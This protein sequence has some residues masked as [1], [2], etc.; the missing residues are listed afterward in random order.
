MFYQ[1]IVRFKRRQPAAIVFCD[2]VPWTRQFSRNWVVIY[3]IFLSCWRKNQS[4]EIHFYSIMQ[5]RKSL[6]LNAVSNKS[7]I[8]VVDQFH[9]WEEQFQGELHFLS[10]YSRW[11]YDQ[12]IPFNISKQRAWAMNATDKIELLCRKLY[13][14]HRFSLPAQPIYRRLISVAIFPRCVS[15]HNYW[16][17]KK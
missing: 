2:V 9:L 8:F 6:P 1:F 3:L 4:I 11:R 7:V 13:G 15:L 17:C 10:F 14:K 12:E 16:S 5:D